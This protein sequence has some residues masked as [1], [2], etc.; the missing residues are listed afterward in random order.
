MGAAMEIKVLGTGCAKCKKLFAE[1]QEAALR[2]GKA[3][4]VVKVEDIQAIMAH[5]VR[6]TPALVVDGQ[7]RATGRI[8][9]ADEIAAWIVQAAE[10]TAG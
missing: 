2:S 5:G 3:V 7:V 8:P 6:Q 10:R 9:G 4:S 1:A